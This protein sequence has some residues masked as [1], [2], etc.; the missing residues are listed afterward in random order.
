MMFK[1]ESM[2]AQRRLIFSPMLVVLACLLWGCGHGHNSTV[3]VQKKVIILGI[4]AMDPGILDRLIREGKMANFERLG[5]TGNL[6][7]VRT[8]IPPES[9]VAWSN[10]ITGMNPGGHGI[11]DFIHRDPKTMTPFLSTSKTEAGGRSVHVGEW[12][13]PLTAG[14]VILLRHGQSFWELLHARGVSTTVLRCPANFPPVKASGTQLSGMGTPDIL[15]GYGTFSFYTDEPLEK[16]QGITGGEVHSIKVSEQTI[17]TRL[18]G[19]RNSFRNK[20]P[21]CEIDLTIYVD[22]EHPVAKIVIQDEQILLREKNW[23]PWVRVKFE[24]IPH[25]QSVTGICRFYLQAIRPHFKLYVSP[26]NLDPASPAMP[27]SEPGDY[28]SRLADQIG[29]FYTQG[30]P[31]DTNALSARILDDGEFL[32]QVRLVSGE[33]LRMFDYEL[34]RFHAGLLYFYFGSID[35]LQHMFWRTMDPRHP[36]HDPANPFTHVIEDAYREMDEV[37]GKTLKKVDEQTTL[38]VIS[39]HGFAP[40]Y[41]AFSLNTWLKNNAY[42][43][44]TNFSEGE[45]LNNVDWNNTRAYGLGFAGLYL[46]LKGREKNGIVEPGRDREALLKELTEKLLA[47]HDP[48]NGEPV[49]LRVYRTD[50][51]YNGPYKQDAPD[52]IIGYNRGYRAS[53]ETT[54]GKFPR[55][56]LRD[57]QEKWSGDH[58]MAPEVVPGILLANKKIKAATPALFDL[59]PSILA[60]FGVSKPDDMVGNNIF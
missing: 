39:D 33:T 12:I 48:K 57:N 49:I 51:V 26:I 11:F 56:L 3:A 58:L 17:R 22:A 27:I 46:N 2:H 44:L 23:S 24:L 4:D 37:L 34:G 42:V 29:L 31:E 47:I 38:I 40:F 18:Q 19:P 13:L 43:S 7:Q 60:E 10:F 45:L 32:E 6:R 25:L 9:P 5:K 16:Y 15:G 41:R 54:L 36:A 1:L 35:A 14:K 21:R 8:S 59:A 50:E 28:S 20:S 52:L 55:E 30:I 53:W